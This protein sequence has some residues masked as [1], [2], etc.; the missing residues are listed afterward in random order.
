MGRK[1]AKSSLTPDPTDFWPRGR[2]LG[3][4]EGTVLLTRLIE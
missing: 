1:K 2:G 3:S 4:A